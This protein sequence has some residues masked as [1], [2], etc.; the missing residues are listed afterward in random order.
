MQIH[1]Q[2]DDEKKEIYFRFIE[3]G[4]HNTLL[5]MCGASKISIQSSDYTKL[6]NLLP[7]QMVY[8]AYYQD[9]A[10][11]FDNPKT[12][13]K[14][15]EEWDGSEE[16][17]LKA[18]R[19]VNTLI[20]VYNEEGEHKGEMRIDLSNFQ[21]HP[22]FQEWLLQGMLSRPTT[23]TPTD[24]NVLGLVSWDNEFLYKKGL[25]ANNQDD[26]IPYLNKLIYDYLVLMTPIGNRE[27]HTFHTPLLEFENWFLQRGYSI[28]HTPSLFDIGDGKVLSNPLSQ[29]L[30]QSDDE[31]KNISAEYSNLIKIHKNAKKEHRRQI[32]L[33]TEKAPEQRFIDM[34]NNNTLD[35]S[36]K[37]DRLIHKTSGAINWTGLARMIGLKDGKTAKKYAEKYAPYLLR[38]DE[39]GYTI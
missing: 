29:A 38:D 7:V 2:T 32:Q 12:K 15:I 17:R 36:I 21:R 39:E 33:V 23:R 8:G 30:K 13:E 25:H 16:S 19:K 28:E 6:K 11:T 26:Y 27:E 4:L 1:N 24:D 31:K 3:I 35:K 37:E 18:I 34:V 10:F 14:H 5:Q 20:D 22:R 9:T